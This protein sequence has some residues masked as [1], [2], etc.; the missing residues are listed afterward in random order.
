[1]KQV[2]LVVFQEPHDYYLIDSAWKSQAKAEARL[3]ELTTTPKGRKKRD[4]DLW[5]VEAVPFEPPST[6][7]TTPSK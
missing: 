3:R 6:G 7:N 2:F 4:H 5:D 1:M